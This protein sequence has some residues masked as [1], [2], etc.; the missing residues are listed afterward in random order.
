M[1][2]ICLYWNI[3][4]MPKY[5]YM[6][7]SCCNVV[8]YIL[9]FIYNSYYFIPFHVRNDQRNSRGKIFNNS[10]QNERE[11]SASIPRINITLQLFISSWLDKRHHFGTFNTIHIFLSSWN[12]V[13]CIVL[14]MDSETLKMIL[15]K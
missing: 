5:P 1:S 13:L 7:N 9:H 11:N 6:I 10:R 14:K 4:M 15:R 8:F 2:W 3:N 12:T